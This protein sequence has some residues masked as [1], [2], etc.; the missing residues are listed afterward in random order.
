MWVVF[1]FEFYYLLLLLLYQRPS[2]LDTLEADQEHVR[3]PLALVK[4]TVNP[5]PTSFRSSWEKPLSL[6]RVGTLEL[7]RER[8]NAVIC[9]WPFGY[10]K[11]LLENLP[12]NLL[13]NLPITLKQPTTLGRS[14]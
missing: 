8:K 10:S 4:G 2:N 1:F 6:L 13:E 5:K 14:S 9:L 12:K 7:L 11:N 3:E